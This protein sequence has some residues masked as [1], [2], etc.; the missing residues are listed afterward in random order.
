[1]KSLET[2]NIDQEFQFNGMEVNKFKRNNEE[3]NDKESEYS[4]N[5]IET[6]SFEPE[7]KPNKLQTNNLEPESRTNYLQTSYGN[8]AE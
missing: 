4:L 1:M 5:S 2:L 3:T 6:V 7:L 8:S